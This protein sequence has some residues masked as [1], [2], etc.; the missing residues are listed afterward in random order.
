MDSL[1]F[2]IRAHRGDA[3][4]LHEADLQFGRTLGGQ[5]ICRSRLD[6]DII[7]QWLS[8]CRSRHGGCCAPVRTKQ[9]ERIWLI[10]V[11]TRKVVP[12]PSHECDYMAL[13]YVWGDQ[14]QP[15]FKEGDYCDSLPQTLEDAIVITKALGKQYLWVDSVCI[16]QSDQNHKNDQI[17]RMWSIYRGSY[18]TIIALSGSSADTGLA[19][20]SNP[21]AF[22]QLTCIHRGRRLVTLMPTLSQQIWRQ[23]W[24]RRGWTFQEALLSPRCLYVS[25]HQLYFD[26]E[27]M[28][29]CESLDETQS[30]AHGL[31]SS[32]NP[33]D[34]GF[35]TWMMSQIGSGA[36]RNALDSQSMRLQ[37][38]GYKVNLYSPRHLTY[39]E[40]GLRAM[41]GVL[42]RLG[43]MYPRGFFWG[44]PIEDL[45]W[46]LLWRPQTPSSRRCDFPSWSWAGW[47]G[48]AW[49]IA[50]QDLAQ[51]RDWPLDLTISKM[52]EGKSE[53]L[54][55]SETQCMNNEVGPTIGESADPIDRAASTSIDETKPSL[56]EH[57][58]AELR[59][60]LLF[61]AVCLHFAPDFSNPLL[62]VHSAAQPEVFLFPI[63]GIS[64]RLLLQSTDREIGEPQKEKTFILLARERHGDYI[65]Y[66]LLLVHFQSAA[67]S[68]CRGTSLALIVP[69]RHRWDISKELHLRRE[70]I[71]LT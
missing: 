68:A 4:T 47:E 9:L 69:A 3:L 29:C 31:T 38:W 56:E 16:D 6:F 14:K 20:I 59:R 1:T 34:E 51:I 39:P 53:I 55:H 62:G 65:L 21:S 52:S 32:S 11:N 24:G 67:S 46:A 12:H 60:Y 54:F 27:A 15:R 70:R 18:L 49:Y 26:C 36:F 42:Q 25:D 64:C 66:H 23:K 37:H 43:T 61:D 5:Q 2:S 44:L 7:E 28:Q 35:V 17:G 40:D 33:T 58:P 57:K 30:H 50:P 63:R 19:R 22:S 13:S 48:G 8:N 10:E 71:L 41:E 45:D